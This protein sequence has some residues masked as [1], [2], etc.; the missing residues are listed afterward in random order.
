M[1]ATVEVTAAGRAYAVPDQV[2]VGLRVESQADAVS[3]ALRG[4]AAGVERL[5]AVLDAAGVRAP[6]R[7]TTGLQVHPRWD[8]H[9]NEHSG[10]TASYGLSV[11]VQDL[12]GA[13][14]LVQVCA[15]E[16]GD[17]LGVEGFALHVRDPEPTREEARRAAVQACR[18][19]AQQLASAAGVR[20]G[21]L[22][23]L[24][25]GGADGRFARPAS[26]RAMVQL[27]SSGA[28]VEAGEHELVVEVTAI[29][30]LVDEEGAP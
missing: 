22:V 30:E 2:L 27:Q 29:W 11:V 3:D 20:L 28:P 4:A 24:S 17:L 8:P 5:L 21:P 9:T 1:T 19:Q 12:D 18:D 13:G 16:V 26:G 15:D 6:D 23:R 25:E 10:Q 7:R 14:R